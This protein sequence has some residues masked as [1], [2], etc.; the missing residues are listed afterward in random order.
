[1]A[2][3]H[4]PMP[5]SIIFANGPY[6][7]HFAP[8]CWNPCL[9]PL[10]SFQYAFGRTDFCQIIFEKRNKKMGGIGHERGTWSKKRR[11]LMF[12]VNR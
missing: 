4:C 6:L 5:N 2:G 8:F 12:S 10:A 3:Y 11:F 7:M 9:M 1:M